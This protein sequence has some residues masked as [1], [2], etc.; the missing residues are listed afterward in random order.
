[1]FL[2]RSQNSNEKQITI[3]AELYQP[4]Y[5]EKQMNLSQS[6]KNTTSFI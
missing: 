1:M 4:H 2:V 3:M 5:N 6:I